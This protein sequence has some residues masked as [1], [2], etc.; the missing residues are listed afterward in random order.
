M[1]SLVLPPIVLLRGSLHPISYMVLYTAPV[2]KLFPVA[3][4]EAPLN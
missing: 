1:A 4:N 3:T 2:V